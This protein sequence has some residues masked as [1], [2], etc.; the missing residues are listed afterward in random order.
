[1]PQKWKAPKRPEHKIT[2]GFNDG[3]VTIFS[4]SDSAAPGYQ[5]VETLTEKI[6]LRYAE[7][8]VGIRRFYDGRQ[9]QTEVERVLRVPRAGD[10]TNRDVAVTEDGTRY[11]IDLVQLAP[12]VW[13][14]SVDLQLVLYTQGAGAGEDPSL[15]SG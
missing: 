11:R 1:M 13:P 7:R 4:V 5:P 3:L 9:N 8:R 6:R 14:P 10:V 15:R 12:D 2:Q